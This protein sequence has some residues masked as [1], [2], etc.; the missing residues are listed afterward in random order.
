MT[1][2][3]HA[4]IAKQPSPRIVILANPKAGAAERADKITQLSQALQNRGYETEIISRIDQFTTATEQLCAKG[5]LRAVI[6]A[7]G[8]GTAAA[9]ANAIG[10]A[11]PLIVFPLGTENLMAKYLGHTQDPH[12]VLQLLERGR[13]IRIDAGMASGRLFL[14]MVSCGMD[15]DVV[16][17]LHRIRRGHITHSTYLKPIFD[18]IRNYNYPPMQIYSQQANGESQLLHSARWVFVANLPVYAGGLPIWPDA[19]PTDGALDLCTFQRG[20]LGFGLWYLGGILLGNHSDWS[21]CQTA[22]CQKIRIESEL[23]VPYQ[24]DGD[25]G[26]YLPVQL[27]VVPGR[28]SVLVSEDCPAVL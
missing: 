7:G 13:T 18:S 23:P 24:L 4:S 5:E 11:V 6:A 12:N 17:R 28:V 15:A 16:R 22:R 21:D 27:E 1:R 19:V 10:P 25:P 14:L 20:S 2:N 9:A 3:S 8:D 26:G